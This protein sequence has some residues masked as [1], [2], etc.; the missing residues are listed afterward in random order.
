MA[1]RSRDIENQMVLGDIEHGSD[2]DNVRDEELVEQYLNALVDGNTTQRKHAT[3]IIDD[4]VSEVFYDRDAACQFI[5]A[6]L[7]GDSINGDEWLMKHARRVITD[8]CRDMAVEWAQ[9]EQS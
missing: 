8:H 1:T 2:L 7:E 9:E 3:A 6:A 5:F 4:L